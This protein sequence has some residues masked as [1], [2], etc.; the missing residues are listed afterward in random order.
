LHLEGRR[1]DFVGESG[2]VLGRAGTVALSESVLVVALRR[3][4]LPMGK[5]DQVMGHRS[6]ETKVGVFF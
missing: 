5:Y 6:G 1:V 2:E 4:F 3:V